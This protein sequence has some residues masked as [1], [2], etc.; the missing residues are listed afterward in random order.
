MKKLDAGIIAYSEKV[1][2][3]AH[4]ATPLACGHARANEVDATMPTGEVLAV[5]SVCLAFERIFAA[6]ESSPHHHDAIPL[7]RAAIS[8]KRCHKR[9]RIPIAT[10]GVTA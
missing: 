10:W 4:A 1:L 5:C 3:R 8:A 2:A 6:L 9:F 7:V